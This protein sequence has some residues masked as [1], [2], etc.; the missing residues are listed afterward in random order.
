[1]FY[2]KSHCP[3]NIPEN[4][5]ENRQTYSIVW[6]SWCPALLLMALLGLYFINLLMLSSLFFYFMLVIALAVWGVNT[7]QMSARAGLTSCMIDWS[8]LVWNGDLYSYH[9][10]HI[11]EHVRGQV[12][13]PPDYEV[14][15]RGQIDISS[16]PLLKLLIDSGLS[17]L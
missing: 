11:D 3:T 2:L 9:T 8:L 4:Y 17:Q 16:R 7:G 12:I 6:F 10:A 13:K 14:E 1:M 5:H 15:S